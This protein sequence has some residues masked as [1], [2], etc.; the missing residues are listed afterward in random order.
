MLE[1]VFVW[2]PYPEAVAAYGEPAYDEC[3]GY[4]PLLVLGG[5]QRV[6]NL[7]EVKLIEHIALITDFAGV[8]PYWRLARPE[9][10]VSLRVLIDVI[11]HFGLF[12]TSFSGQPPQPASLTAAAG[13][14]QLS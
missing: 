7:Q 14:C 2:S 5:P 8:I 10:L 11:A 3:F 9:N 4:V 12:L 13:A 6:E 1:D